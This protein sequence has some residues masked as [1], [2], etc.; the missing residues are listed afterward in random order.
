MTDK[1]QGEV[2][3]CNRH[4]DAT[5]HAQRKAQLPGSARGGVERQDLYVAGMAVE[6]GR[7]LVIA[8][9]KWDAVTDRDKRRREIRERV[10]DSLQQARGVP[11]VTLSAAITAMRAALEAIKPGSNTKLPPMVDFP[12]M[13]Q[14]VGFP[15]YWER[16]ARYK[17]A[18]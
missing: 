15:A 2:E 18:E 13:Q 8:A 4:D 3:R 10:E 1:I 12:E 7:A 11:I 17:A 14:I 5:R 9:N 16:E 6:E